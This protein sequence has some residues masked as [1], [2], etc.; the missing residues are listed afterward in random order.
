MWL[1]AQVLESDGS[2]ICH[3][4]IIHLGQGTKSSKTQILLCKKDCCEG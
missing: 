3:L 4:F 2:G 1:K